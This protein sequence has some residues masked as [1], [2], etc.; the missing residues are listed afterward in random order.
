VSDLIKSRRGEGGW[1]HLAEEGF[2]P[3]QPLH[4]A[5]VVDAQGPVVR[6]E[7]VHRPLQLRQ[8]VHLVLPGLEGGVN[9]R[10]ERSWP[11]GASTSSSTSAS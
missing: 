1:P 8:L 10:S 7:H 3:E 11:G 4:V 5:V 9:Q 6:E 2:G